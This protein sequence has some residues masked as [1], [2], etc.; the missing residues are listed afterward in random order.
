MIRE[1]GICGDQRGNRVRIGLMH[2]I[3][4]RGALQRCDIQIR[5]FDAFSQQ[6]INRAGVVEPEGIPVSGTEAGMLTLLLQVGEHRWCFKGAKVAHIILQ[7][8]QSLVAALGLVYALPLRVDRE[9]NL[10][11]ALRALVVPLGNQRFAVDLVLV[12]RTALLVPVFLE[13]LEAVL[14]DAFVGEVC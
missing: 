6:R 10:F 8:K 4:F 7:V 3:G 5:L 13:R 11:M 14:L 12:D 1:V 9:R 2:R